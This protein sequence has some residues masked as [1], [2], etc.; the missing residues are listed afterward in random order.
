MVEKLTAEVHELVAEVTELKNEIRT[1]NRRLRAVGVAFTLALLATAGVAVVAFDASGE[2]EDAAATANAAIAQ[3]EAERALAREIACESYN[4]DTVDAIN[5]I[6]LTVAAGS[7]NPDALD[8]VARL[9]LPHRDCSTTGI[10]AYF[11]GD[12]ATDP[13]IPTELP[14]E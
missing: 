12:P 5:G 13:F 7:D 2:A 8:R 11:D 4:S 1:R 9:L 14:I 6:L 10:D 3:V